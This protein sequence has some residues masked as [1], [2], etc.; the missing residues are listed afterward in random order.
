[1]AQSALGTP[2][3]SVESNREHDKSPKAPSLMQPG[4][5]LNNQFS[6]VMPPTLGDLAAASGGLASFSPPTEFMPN[7]QRGPRRR[8]TRQDQ[9]WTVTRGKQLW[10]WFL[11]VDPSHNSPSEVKV[12]VSLVLQLSN[13]SHRRTV[14]SQE[15]LARMDFIGLKQRPLMGPSWPDRTYEGR[16]IRDGCGKGWSTDADC[17]EGAWEGWAEP[18]VNCCCLLHGVLCLALHPG[19]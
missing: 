13:M 8:H 7:T 15:A 18:S 12:K 10:P 9:G 16:R 14:L 17:N 4:S 2:R 11:S 6:L 5:E 1:M 19:P 3:D